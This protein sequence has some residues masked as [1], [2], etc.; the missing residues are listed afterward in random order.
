MSKPLFESSCGFCVEFNGVDKE[1]NLLQ[2]VISPAYNI[3]SRIVYETDNFAVIPTLGAIVEGYLLVVSKKHYECIGQLPD[4]LFPELERVIDRVKLVTWSVY[5]KNV[6]CFEHGA[7][8]CSNKFGGCIDHA[9]LHIVPCGDVLSGM[10]TDCG[11]ELV[12]IASIDALSCI[13]G[14]NQPYLYWEDSDSRK[15][16][17]QD[18]FIPSQFCRKIIADYYSVA[19]QWDWRQ[20][21]NLEN[22][23][24]TYGALQPV[25]AE[26]A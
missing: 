19:E 15:Y 16:V 26:R 13:A 5:K 3:E 7:V 25:F 12:P 10:I 11:M 24:K 23:L 1:N 17:I 21:L 14:K 22:L 2:R 6:V 8:S 9:H 18:G 20:N 4:D